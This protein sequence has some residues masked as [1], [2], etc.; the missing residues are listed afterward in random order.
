MSTL[1]IRY[2]S[3]KTFH[4]TGGPADATVDSSG[5]IDLSSVAETDVGISWTLNDGK[6]FR[7]S[8][9]AAAVSISGN[10][11]A[12]IFT[13]GTLSNENKTYTVTD[14]NA[15]GA[16]NKSF[17]YQMHESTGDVDPSITNR[18]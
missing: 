7:S 8:G 12:Q 11:N 13:N 1:A 5:N 16:L 18:N 2:D 3:D 15:A 4:K 6:V 10:G 9:N 14:A 17:T